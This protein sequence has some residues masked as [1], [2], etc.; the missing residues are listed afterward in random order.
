MFFLPC[1]RIRSC[2]GNSNESWMHQATDRQCTPERSRKECFTLFYYCISLFCSAN[3]NRRVEES[4]FLAPNGLVIKENQRETLAFSIQR[5][6]DHCRLAASHL[7]PP[8]RLRVS[9][10][11]CASRW[12]RQSLAMA[13]GPSGRGEGVQ[14]VMWS[15]ARQRAGETGVCGR[16]H[17]GDLDWRWDCFVDVD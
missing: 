13:A 3:T 6:V 14:C 8:L 9:P 12:Q 15:H 17:Q 11:G 16:V 5:Q 10:L 2:Q 7:A 4:S 1:P